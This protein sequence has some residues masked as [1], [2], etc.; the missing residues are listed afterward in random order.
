MTTMKRPKI[1]PEVL[2][3]YVREST[4]ASAAIEG[5]VVPPGFKRSPQVERFLAELK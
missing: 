5:R 4:R 3:R 1:D 2:R